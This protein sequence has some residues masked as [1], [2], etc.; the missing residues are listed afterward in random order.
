MK[1]ETTGTQTPRDPHGVLRLHVLTIVV[2]HDMKAAMKIGSQT[3]T[4]KGLTSLPIRTLQDM[5]T[6]VFLLAHVLIETV[7]KGPMIDSEICQEMHQTHHQRMRRVVGC[8]KSRIT[9]ID[10]KNHNM[11]DL[12]QGQSCLRIVPFLEMTYL[13]AQGCRMATMPRRCGQMVGITAVHNLNPLLSRRSTQA[14][15]LPIQ[16][17][18]KIDRL[19]R[20]HLLGTPG[21]H[22]LCQ[23]LT[24]LKFHRPQVKVQIQQVFTRTV[25]GQFKE[26]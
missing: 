23:G 4:V 13:L 6:T 9:I 18:L 20:V 25:C 3:T 11:A 14:Y 24:L 12:T 5:T 10:S 7:P 17:K 22:C 15:L 21:S 1:E 16:R 19:L 26:L 2:F 8:T